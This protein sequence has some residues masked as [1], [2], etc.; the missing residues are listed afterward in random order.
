MQEAEQ[1]AFMASDQIHLQ[2]TFTI[3]RIILLAE[4]FQIQSE[5]TL[6]HLLQ[7]LME[8]L[9]KTL[10]QISPATLSETLFPP[11]GRARLATLRFA[12]LMFSAQ[13]VIILYLKTL[14]RI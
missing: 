14:Y 13:V 7:E 8:F 12:V 1:E 9:M 4:L 11:E 3:F 5:V 10:L 6:H 2:R